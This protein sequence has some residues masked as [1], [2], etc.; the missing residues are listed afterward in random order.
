MAARRRREGRRGQALV[1]FALV[2]PI[3]LLLILGLVDFARAWNA[4]QVI[5]DAAREGAR[6]A[7]IN[8]A[9]ITEN[10]VKTVVGAAL[11][12]ASLDPNE[13]TTVITITGLTD[14]RGF[15]TTVR[16]EHQ[17]QLGWVG[18]LMALAQGSDQLTLTSEIVMRNE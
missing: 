14:G 17:Y 2:A 1:E 7:V 4:Y 9:T 11:T 10:E 12:R 16:I 18:A 15:P 6:A 5:T 3:L 8:N 13:P